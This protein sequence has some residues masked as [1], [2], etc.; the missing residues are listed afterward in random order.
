L[1]NYAATLESDWLIHDIDDERIAAARF[2]GHETFAVRHDAGLRAHDGP[3]LDQPGFTLEAIRLDHRTPSLGYIL[4]E[5]PSLMVDKAALAALGMKPG[6]WLGMVKGGATGSVVIDGRR[7]DVATLRAQLLV[8]APQQSL[9]FLTDFRLDAE[10]H[11]M[12]VPRLAGVDCLVCEGQYAGADI[13]LALRHHHATISQVA[14]LAREAAVSDLVLVHLSRRYGPQG[15]QA[16]LAEARAI[17]PKARF[18]DH[19]Q[20]AEA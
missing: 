15:W 18:P 13:A 17:F 11:A 1:W 4:R 16:M 19:W 9:A 20:I 2:R 3:M 8:P 14:S 5:K 6:R 12:L 7:H 10:T